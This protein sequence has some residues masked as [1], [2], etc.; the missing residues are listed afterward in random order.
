MLTRLWRACGLYRGTESE[1]MAAQADNPDGFWEHLSF[2]WV[3]DELLVS[4][5]AR[6]ISR[7]TR[8]KTF[9]A[10]KWTHC[11]QKRAS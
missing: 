6:G 7:Q 2:D 5:V 10:P 9:S 3:K 4:S 1:L 8:T 11:A